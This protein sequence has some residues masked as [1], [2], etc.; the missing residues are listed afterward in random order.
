MLSS[1]LPELRVC[2]SEFRSEIDIITI[3][4]HQKYHQPAG[5][6]RPGTPEKSPASIHTIGN[7]PE[8]LAVRLF[9]RWLGGPASL[10]DVTLMWGLD[11]L[12]KVVMKIRRTKFEASN[13]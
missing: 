8:Q 2:P 11:Q 6:V 12:R 9:C 4:R 7:P 10:S 3:A 5:E 1:C 13:E